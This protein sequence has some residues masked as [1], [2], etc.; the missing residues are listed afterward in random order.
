MS[1]SAES[2]IP[3]DSQKRLRRWLR[4]W[5][6]PELARS[7]RVEFSPRLVRA[8]GRCYQQDRLIRL[9]PSLRTSQAW[10]LDEIL[11][12]EAAHAAVWHLHR[13][14]AR[15]H[16]EEWKEM[17]RAAGFRPRV[18]LP[19]VVARPPARGP[20][21]EVVRCAVC[22]RACR[23]TRKGSAKPRCTACA[24]ARPR[25]RPATRENAAQPRKARASS[26]GQR[27]AAGNATSV[28]RPRRDGAVSA[29]RRRR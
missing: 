11:C 7:L 19:F 14:R 12:H 17:M 26:G 23:V 27:R 1:A 3:A 13:D 6:T 2:T 5:G 18:R 22:E 24:G 21:F 28:A 8:F 25:L 10:L 4:R 20:A 9:T 16:G 29:T 15:P